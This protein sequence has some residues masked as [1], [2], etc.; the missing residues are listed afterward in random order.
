MP[1]QEMVRVS[2][3]LTRREWE[4]AKQVGGL[5]GVPVGFS[6]LAR[7]LLI[8]GIKRAILDGKRPRD[9]PQG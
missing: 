9:A 3:Y 1:K 8:R 6:R 2:M 4:L 5:Q 7:R